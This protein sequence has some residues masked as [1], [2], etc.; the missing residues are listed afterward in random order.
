[1]LSLFLVI[2]L[3]VSEV[4]NVVVLF[5]FGSWALLLLWALK[6][7]RY[8]SAD[9]INADQS[10]MRFEEIKEKIFQRIK[11]GNIKDVTL[12]RIE[13]SK[14]IDLY[15]ISREQH[16]LGQMTKSQIVEMLINGTVSLNDHFFDEH[17]GEWKT[18][19]EMGDLQ[20]L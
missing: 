7:P 2:G 20:L 4:G 3:K 15:H 16:I 9:Q 17:S 12:L 8:E 13:D 19:K 1:M 11:A 18:L 10:M 5:M 6:G 14:T